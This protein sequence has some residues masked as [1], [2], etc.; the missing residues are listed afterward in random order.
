MNVK[1]DL[2]SDITL[3][4]RAF[5][6]MGIAGTSFLAA[7]GISV[8]SQASQRDPIFN[9]PL[10]LQPLQPADT[11]GIMLPP[12]F[13]SRIVARSSLP[14]TDSSDYVWHPSPDGGA[15]FPTVDG[16]WIYVSNSEVG[17]AKG[18]VGALRFSAAGAV[19]DSYSI[20]QNTTD[21]C[22]GGPTPW[23][24]WLTCEEFE[25]GQ[26]YECDPFG[27][28]PAVL[29][30]A[31]GSFAHEAV[32]IDIK[33]DCAYLT[34]DR[35]DGGLYRFTATNGLPDLSRGT[36]EIAAVVVR[37]SEKFVEWK[38][39][40]DPH[41]RTK[42]TRRQVASYQPFAGGEGIAIQDGVVYFTTKHDNRVWRYDTRSNQLDIL[43]EAGAINNSILTG[44]DNLVISPAGDVLVAED[45]GDMQIV[46]ISP[47]GKPMPLLQIIN[48]DKSEIAG[49]AFDPSHTRLYF[50]SQR[51][52]SGIGTDGITY[53]ISRVG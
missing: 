41:A 38:A 49:P 40:D 13:K 3:K 27:K 34:E 31:M 10:D 11:N 36:L 1:N 23:G 20:C 43:Y 39:V 25:M 6:R 33:N 29:R 26:V 2:M 12:G 22:A 51:G 5:L 4:R 19:I 37:G 9:A 47:E 15:C 44:V 8:F 14:A 32:A 45:R 53:E 50:S 24:T 52:Q 7:G 30:E 16:G 21:N 46:S 18:G 28:N 35:P 42:P 17:G 48:H